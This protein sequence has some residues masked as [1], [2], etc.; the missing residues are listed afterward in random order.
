M[1]D[2][3]IR[4]LIPFIIVFASTF[5]LSEAE[6]FEDFGTRFD[7]LK[8]NSRLFALLITGD[9][10]QAIASFAISLIF[11]KSWYKNREK[12]FWFNDLMWQLAGAFFCWFIAAAVAIVGS[13]WQYL[14]LNGMFRLFAGI[15]MVYVANTVIAARFKMFNPETPQEA[16]SKAQKFDEL[17]KI[18]SK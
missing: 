14:W 1:K 12:E 11:F 13:F 7:M 6:F 9:A 16:Q 18:I 17:I 10:L 3:Q 5:F 15:F 2:R 8:E 4:A